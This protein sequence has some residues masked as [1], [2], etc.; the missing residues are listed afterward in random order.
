MYKIFEKV[1]KTLIINLDKDRYRKSHAQEELENK[2]QNYEFIK[3]ISHNDDIVKDIYKQ[4]KVFSYPPCFRCKVDQCLH[5]NNFLTPKQ[6]ANFL[7]F[8]KV[9]QITLE[10]NYKNVIVIEDD[11]KFSR[12][13]S[14]S[15]KNLDKY[16]VQNNLLDSNLPVLFRIGSHTVVNKKYYLKLFTLRKNT[17]LIDNFE[18]MANPCFLINDKFAELFLS[19]FDTIDTT[20]DDYIHRRIAKKSEVL[21]FSIYPFPVSQLSYGRKNNQFESSITSNSNKKN[22]SDLNK[23]KSFNDYKK[24][25]DEWLSS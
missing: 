10:R 13:S 5:K 9:M 19:S 15:F 4:N 22:F 1:D 21:N 20:S 3:A 18:N 14:L 7:S 24:F 2:S 6:V 8:S 17:F 23:I 12:H 11:F 16:I 25:K